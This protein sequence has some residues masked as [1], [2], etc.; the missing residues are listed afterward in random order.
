MTARKFGASGASLW[1]E[2]TTAYVLDPAEEAL[3]AQACRTVDELERIEQE[4]AG[5]ELM[6]KGSM[7]QPVPNPLLEQARAHRKVL[8]A[9]C[10]S[11]ALPLPSEQVG[12]RRN[13]QHSQAA[14]ARHRTA[15]LRSVRGSA[16]GSA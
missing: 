3:L 16:D 10:R 13:P 9:L 12:N 14:K 6:V 1:R 4:L 15:A 5:A 2:V 7:G 11:L 8:D